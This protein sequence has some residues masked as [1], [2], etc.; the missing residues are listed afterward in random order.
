M[1]FDMVVACYDVSDETTVTL[2]VTKTVN[3][4]K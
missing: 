3:Y 4:Q 1:A 2:N